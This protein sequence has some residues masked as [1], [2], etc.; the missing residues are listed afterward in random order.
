[1]ELHGACACGRNEYVVR[2]TSSAQLASV[3]FDNTRRARAHHA[4]SPFAAF[5]RVPLNWLS[6]STT[7]FFPDEQPNHIR[8]TFLE[9]P[10]PSGSAAYPRAGIRRQ[11]CGYCGTPLSAWHEHTKEDADFISLTLGSLRDSDVRKLEDMGLFNGSSDEEERQ[12]QVQSE[13]GGTSEVGLQNA[14]LF[15]P[16]QVTAERGA[17][18]FETM[19][20]DSRLGKIRKTRGVYSS[21][22]GSVRE[23][24]EVVEWS[25]GVDEGETSGSAKR[26][27][28]DVANEDSDVKMRG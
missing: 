26:K 1:M 8:R 14:D 12:E 19:I 16:L 27:L 22:D 15:G 11:F 9:Q 23:E 2:P 3:L 21:T 7:P 13:S 4:A 18:W 17:P 28:V 20:E 10:P 6:S 25:D 5:L 24:W